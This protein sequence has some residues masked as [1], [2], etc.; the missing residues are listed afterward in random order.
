MP[1]EITLENPCSGP[2]FTKM[3]LHMHD[4]DKRIGH[5]ELVIRN[6]PPYDLVL[7]ILE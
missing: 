5:Y 1:I 2:S 4:H 3:P 7:A 6:A